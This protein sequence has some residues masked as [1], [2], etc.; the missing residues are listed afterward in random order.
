[1]TSALQRH[2]CVHAGLPDAGQC[3]RGC[4]VC[5]CRASGRVTFAARVIA[6]TSPQWINHCAQDQRSS[7]TWC[8]VVGMRS[9]GIVA[10]RE[11]GIDP[12][13]MALIPEPGTDLI[14][15]TSALLD[16][17]DLIALAGTGQ[18]RPTDRQRLAAKGRQRGAV[19]PPTRLWPGADLRVA[20]A[21]APG[22]DSAATVTA[23]CSSAAPKSAAP[24]APARGHQGRKATV[25]LPGPAGA[26]G[27]L[28]WTGPTFARAAT[29]R[30][31]RSHTIAKPD[32]PHRHHRPKLHPVP[33][34]SLAPDP[35]EMLLTPLFA[36][37]RI[38]SRGAF[39]S[40]APARLDS[41]PR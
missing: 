40:R 36:A 33:L 6:K 20:L 16:G 10:A 14:A 34:M 22:A 32:R 30:Y 26:A 38:A 19:L 1:V 11:A 21:R 12:S 7:G 8:A 27:G 39:S 9:L 28:D 25:L 15:V 5:G 2:C 18:L 24:A 4:G 37:A 41:L 35:A 3:D 31:C 13:R 23:A 17:I 29:P